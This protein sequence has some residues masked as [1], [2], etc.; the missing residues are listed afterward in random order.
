[1][2]RHQ[3]KDSLF[4]SAYLTLLTFSLYWGKSYSVTLAYVNKYDMIFEEA[5][6]IVI[7]NLNFPLLVK[8]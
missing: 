2:T 7:N 6:S 5:E 3:W 8:M 4:I 1:M